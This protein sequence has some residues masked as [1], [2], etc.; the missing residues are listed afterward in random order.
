MC[1]N[2]VKCSRKWPHP[3]YVCIH[4]ETR[5]PSKSHLLFC[6]LLT[7]W[8]IHGLPL[9]CRYS[10]VAWWWA[11]SAC[12]YSTIWQTSD[13]ATNQTGKTGWFLQILWTWPHKGRYFIWIRLI[14]GIVGR[15]FFSP[16]LLWNYDY[17]KILRFYMI[18]PSPISILLIGKNGHLGIFY[19]VTSFLI[20][21]FQDAS[22]QW[23]PRLNNVDHIHRMD[24]HGHL[25]LLL[26]RSK[27]G[28]GHQDDGLCSQMKHSQ[29]YSFP[30]K[31]GLCWEKIWRHKWDT[32]I[33]RYVHDMHVAFNTWFLRLE[34]FAVVGIL[35]YRWN[36]GTRS[37]CGPVCRHANSAE[38]QAPS[39]SFQW[40]PSFHDALQPVRWHN[41]Y[42]EK[43]KKG[44]DFTKKCRTF[45]TYGKIW[46]LWRHICHISPTSNGSYK[47]HLWTWS[48]DPN[49]AIIKSVSVEIGWQQTLPLSETDQQLMVQWLTSWWF[50]PIWKIFVKLGI[51]PK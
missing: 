38:R 37:H 33:Y 16:H 6:W 1:S 46:P 27:H 17:P 11:M 22:D 32:L 49:T 41:T 21:V 3:W 45:W 48:L 2:L 10:M 43:R 47:R 50:Q 4:T 44:V 23:N 36:L 9:L 25:S 24:P 5:P 34:Q 51:F 42:T 14:S 19:G 15:F 7:T 40:T 28:G 26:D 31:K 8:V 20:Y 39:V 13:K 30:R 35:W 29:I 12:W 18:L